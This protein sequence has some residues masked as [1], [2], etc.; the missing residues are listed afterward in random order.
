AV[1]GGL[2]RASCAGRWR[3]VLSAL[4]VAAVLAVR[5]PAAALAVEPSTAEGRAATPL[6]ATP[7]LQPPPGS[8]VGTQTVTLSSTT[9]GALLRYTTDGSVPTRKVGS[10]YR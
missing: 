1:A 3:V 2:A 9:A 4:A 7:V 5:G 8:Y 10:N 6:T